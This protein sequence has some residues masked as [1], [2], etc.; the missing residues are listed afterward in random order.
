MHDKN[1]IGGLK[2]MC[3]EAKP[4]SPLASPLKN[5]KEN[6]KES[7]K[8]KLQQE[9]TPPDELFGGVHHPSPGIRPLNPPEG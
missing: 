6:K 3:A 2:L 7:Y 4:Y 1:L 9:V 5:K 8:E